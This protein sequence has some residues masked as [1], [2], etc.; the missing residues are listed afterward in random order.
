MIATS[1]PMSQLRR[2]T[3]EPDAAYIHI[4]FCAHKCGYCDFAS[5]AGQDERI[6]DYIEAL[7][8]EMQ[9][10][11]GDRRTVRTIFV[12]GGT[13]T[14]PSARQVERIMANIARWFD[15]S[16]AEEF[17]VES[18]PNTVDPDK[19]AVLA[20]H[21]VNRISFGAQSF[22]RP[23]LETLERNHDPDSVGKAVELARRRIANVSIDLI[24]GVPGQTM[25]QWQTDL[26][27]AIA[28]N[29]VHLSAYGLQYEKGTRLWKQRELG[30]VQPIDEE[31]ERS[32][33]EY[34][35]DRLSGTEWEQYEIS[36]YAR[37]Q[38]D[39][40][41]RC[42]HNLVYWANHAYFGFGTGAAAY[43]QGVRSLNTR[44]VN[45]YI[46]RSRD[47]RSP[48]TQ[49]E[50]LE[51]EQRARETAMLNLRRIRGLV[52]QEFLDQTGFSIDD[53]A[54]VAIGDFVRMG[55]LADDGASIRL[56]REGLP[57][58]DGVLRS[59]L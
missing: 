55:Y 48:I 49:S 7:N 37:R 43:V 30:I 6:D 54:G 16:K 46:E 22:H 3:L 28:L 9:G 32:M 1:P 24:F 36:N 8:A 17:T 34:T 40:D 27:R 25:A 44:D 26:D 35:M 5:V 47:G 23:M 12:G 13:P 15:V 59:M 41:L 20:D 52:R 10:I 50:S 39:R 4:P 11:L 58:G 38:P 18:N 42:Q 14:Y 2:L 19:I 53:L 33:L 45:A 56:T 31:I 29:P 21:G 51:P 57:V